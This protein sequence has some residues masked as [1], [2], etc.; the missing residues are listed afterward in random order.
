MG[1]KNASCFRD[2]VAIR[3]VKIFL[4]VMTRPRK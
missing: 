1:K 4:T 3:R 2:A